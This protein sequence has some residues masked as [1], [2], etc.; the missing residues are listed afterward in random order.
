MAPCIKSTSNLAT[1]GKAQYFE[2]VMETGSE[3]YCVCA[4]TCLLE[5]P[6]TPLEYCR[7]PW[8]TFVHGGTLWYPAVHC[9][10][11]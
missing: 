8:Y 6:G 5:P 9:G 10:T 11:L 3:I 1:C 7:T 4:N 2:F